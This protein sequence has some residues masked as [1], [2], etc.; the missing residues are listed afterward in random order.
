[1]SLHRLIRS[2]NEPATQKDCCSGTALGFGDSGAL[3]R[4]Q[5]V[6]ARH[7]RRAQ[8][9]ACRVANGS[10]SLNFV[11]RNP[12]LYFVSLS[13]NTSP[14]R[15]RIAA[16]F[17]ACHRSPY[18]PRTMGDPLFNCLCDGGIGYSGQR[19]AVQHVQREA[20]P[21]LAC[22]KRSDMGNMVFPMPGVERHRLIET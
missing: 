7:P 22:S 17:R 18:C 9:L 2:A 13:Q 20:L 15:L 3:G 5:V 21:T 12:G 8:S 10:S 4:V 6:P 14:G 1:M 16:D 11:Q 19:L